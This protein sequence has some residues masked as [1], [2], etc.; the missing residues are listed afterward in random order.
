LIVVD[1]SAAVEVLLGLPR[2]G[3]VGTRLLAARQIHGPQLLDLE[4]LQV[5]RRMVLSRELEDGR[6][7]QAVD[8]LASLRIRRWSHVPLRERVWELRRNVTA[9]DA[10]YIALAERFDCPLLTCDARLARSSGH[11]VRVE[12]L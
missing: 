11:R 8:D 4:V 1:A 12:A 3:A 6:A 5:L 7:R 9:Y 2:S 10:V